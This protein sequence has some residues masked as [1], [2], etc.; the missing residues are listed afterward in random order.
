ME[1]TGAS[2]KFLH[3]REPFQAD[4]RAENK[5]KSSEDEKRRPSLV[6]PLAKQCPNRQTDFMAGRPSADKRTVR[7]AKRA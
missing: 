7:R 5:K 1:K 6:N 3:Y 4:R 2:K